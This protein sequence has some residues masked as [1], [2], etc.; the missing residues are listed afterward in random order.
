MRNRSHQALQCVRSRAG[1]FKHA[2]IGGA[3]R[4]R[5]TGRLRGRRLVPGRYLMRAVPRNAAGVGKSA[6]KAFRIKKR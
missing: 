6:T 5:F 2:D 3:N 1:S 4:F